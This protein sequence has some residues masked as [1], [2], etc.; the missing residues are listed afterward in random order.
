MHGQGG[1]KETK[2]I[3]EKGKERDWERRHMAILD[4]TKLQFGAYTFV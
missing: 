2:R 4:E 3:G 1:G